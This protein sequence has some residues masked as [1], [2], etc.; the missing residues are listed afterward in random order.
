MK[1]HLLTLAA[2]ILMLISAPTSS[3]LGQEGHAAISRIQDPVILTG[4]RMPEWSGAPLDEL[5]LYAYHKSGGWEQIPW[6]FDEVQGGIYVSAEDT[7]LD[8][9]D[10][11]AFMA[12]D[13]GEQAQTTQWISDASARSHA[14]YEILV[15]DPL[16]PQERCWVYLYRSTTLSK[17][18]ARDYA[19]FNGHTA[20]SS[21]Y[22]LTMKKASLIA[23]TLKL[24]GSA[25][26]VLDRT[27]VRVRAGGLS[28]TE[29]ELAPADP[30][31]DWYSI[32]DGDVRAITHFVGYDDETSQ[33]W[34]LLTLTNYRS[35]FHEHVSLDLSDV[36]AT[37]DLFRYSADLSPAMAGGT[38]YD[39]NTPAGVAVDG[40]ADAVPTTPFS[41]WNQVSHPTLGTI[42][43][44]I[45]PSPL[46]GT[47]QT[48]YR[49]DG[50]WSSADTGDHK[51]YADPGVLVSQSNANLM[52]DVWYYILPAAQPNVGAG[53]A[54]ASTHPLEA[55]ATR[56]TFASV[57]QSQHALYIPLIAS[58]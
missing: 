29:D 31:S 3:A 47:P 21:I 54:A 17:S 44:I 35:M 45:D 22:Q 25:T 2:L 5:F 1:T 11:L 24:F 52:F 27:K 43:Q 7:L 16:H 36:I 40:H 23:E 10:E 39:A 33:T 34:V 49:D 41:T 46:G 37:L 55:Q 13:C 14:R 20:S 18:T 6:Q 38:Y 12:R 32:R 4:D 50:A 30:R 48:Y 58:Q 15:T 51:S 42:V 53:Y 8:G 28:I 9:D 57:P 19:G 56:Q 26:D